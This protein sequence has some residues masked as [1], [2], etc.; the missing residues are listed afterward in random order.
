MSNQP[1]TKH[2]KVSI[3]NII[4]GV[5]VFYLVFN[6]ASN[7]L[8]DTS[9][10][11]TGASLTPGYYVAFTR[12]NLMGLASDKLIIKN[13]YN[14]QTY[15]IK[16]LPVGSIQLV[17]S[18]IQSNN[19]FYLANIDYSVGGILSSY[20]LGRVPASVEEIH[21]YS[22]SFWFCTNGYEFKRIMRINTKNG[23]VNDIICHPTGN[24]D[25]MQVVFNSSLF[26]TNYDYRIENYVNGSQLLPKSWLPMNISK[27]NEIY[28]DRNY[29]LYFEFNKEV[30]RKISSLKEM[31]E[32]STGQ[33]KL[34]DLNSGLARNINIRLP[35]N[36]TY[37]DANAY[38]LKV[39]SERLDALFFLV[40]FTEEDK[41]ALDIYRFQAGAVDSSLNLIATCP[42]GGTVANHI[43][44]NPN[45]VKGASTYKLCLI[46]PATNSDANHLQ[47]GIKPISIWEIDYATMSNRQV[48]VF[49]ITEIGN[50]VQQPIALS[51]GEFIVRSETG[52][53]L[54][55][56]DNKYRWLDTSP[57]I[58]S[59]AVFSTTQ[60]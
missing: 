29:M 42:I 8:T 4:I 53:A 47:L 52:I 7:R 27:V 25:F 11:R 12:K 2:I 14:N 39:N 35:A 38:I 48:S 41:L 3:W 18:P 50:L 28:F 56:N 60:N 22:S 9:I 30:P 34:L 26:N 6:I 45:P 5:T 57:D 23:L 33:L 59:I 13:I 15:E 51:T 17:S 37:Y 49:P 32:L 19:G 55:A 21:G 44:L 10:I 54:I 58:T 43:T 20:L 36:L 46:G 24:G 16:Q 40:R 31:P 1:T